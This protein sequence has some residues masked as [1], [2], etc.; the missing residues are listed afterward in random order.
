MVTPFFSEIMGAAAGG[1]GGTRPPV[2]NYEGDVPPKVEGFKYFCIELTTYFTFFKICKIK[3]T[4]IRGEIRMWVDGFDETKSV[5]PVKTLWRR[6]C[7]K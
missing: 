6:L 4:E 1:D 7:Q 2:Q 3:V 5:S